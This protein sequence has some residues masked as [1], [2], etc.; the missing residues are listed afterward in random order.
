MLR[1]QIGKLDWLCTLL[2]GVSAK[3]LQGITIIVDVRRPLAAGTNTASMRDKLLECFSPSLCTSIDEHFCAF[4]SQL[5]GSDAQPASTEL[6]VGEE[7]PGTAA[8]GDARTLKYNYSA[9]RI[10]Q[11]ALW[12]RNETVH[13]VYRSEEWT[14]LM[15]ARFPLLR[16][17]N[18]LM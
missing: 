12:V 4:E 8:A 5:D 9:L 18:M 6:S 13:S 7:K 10:V 2:Q 3:T 15:R 11:L 1:V 14:T 16:A 17:R